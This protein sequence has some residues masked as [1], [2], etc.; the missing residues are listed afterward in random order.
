MKNLILILGLA[1]AVLLAGCATSKPVARSAP[2]A[3]TVHV[4]V[5]PKAG[6]HEPAL[7]S[8]FAAHE[9]KQVGHIRQI[10]VRVLE[11][12]ADKLERVLAS[13]KSH[14][15]IKF[16]EQDVR[17]A[18]AVVPDDTYYSL[19][20]HLPKISAPAAWDVTTG[21]SNV[22]IAILDSGINAA[23]PD[24]APLIVP[25]WNVF[26]NNANTDDLSGHGTG[27]AGNAAAVGNN[28]LGIA[29]VAWGCRL[30]PVRVTDVGGWATDQMIA[31]GLVYA[32]EHGAKVANASFGMVGVSS[33]LS[34]AAEYFQSKGGVFT[35]AAGNDASFDPTPDDRYILRV[36][37]TDQS[38]VIA[39]FSATGNNLDL[40]AP[41]VNIVTTTRSGGYG[42][43][44][45]TS[46]S[47]PIVAGVAAL[48]LSVNPTLTPGQVRT[49]LK[50][51]ADDLGAAGWDTAYGWGR[52]NAF[53][54]VQ[55]APTNPPE[56]IVVPGVT[57]APPGSGGVVVPVPDT[58]LPIVVIT[59]P[60][61]GA[62]VTKNVKVIATASDNVG[63]VR[64][65]FWAASVLKQTSTSSSPTFYW[66][67]KRVAKGSYSLEVVAYDLAG[68]V[69]RSVVVVN[70]WP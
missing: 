17:R 64:V 36:N 44:T 47:A 31:V 29:A 9:A 63:V 51:T 42:S 21:S 68:N 59:S 61:N 8:L 14:S 16:A 45:G 60:L 41:G 34:A 49:I 1:G 35:V 54:A 11:V 32:A 27:V 3:A 55:A 13:L 12:R 5:K 20:W 25:G 70:K 56:D 2:G 7:Q 26:D 24:L 40:C 33:T 69:G 6:V 22:V 19:A 46:S 58:T 30:M 43:A 4:L 18:P 23:H 48:V 10:N 39:S 62:K 57:N 38:D 28:L 50:Q 53:R 67:T 15:K 66:D 37:A 65:E 52:V